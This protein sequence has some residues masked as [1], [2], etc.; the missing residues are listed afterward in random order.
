MEKIR[1]GQILCHSSVI[2]LLFALLSFPLFP[3]PTP[4]HIVI[5]PFIRRSLITHNV[6]TIITL[7]IITIAVLLLYL[8]TSLPLP[9]LPPLLPPVYCCRCHL[10]CFLSAVC[11]LSSS[12]CLVSAME[13]T[14]FLVRLLRQT[15]WQISWLTSEEMMER[16]RGE[17]KEM[18]KSVRIG[19]RRWESA[20]KNDGV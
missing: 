14:Y 19:G 9:F 8:P 3:S 11:I 17:A 12:S 13:Q 6:I 20:Y 4:Y 15:G 10:S 16:H 7:L 18:M 1:K 2:T 5:T